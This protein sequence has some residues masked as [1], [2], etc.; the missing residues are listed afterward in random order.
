MFDEA[1]AAH[2]RID[3]VVSTDG[4]SDRPLILGVDADGTRLRFFGGD[5]VGMVTAE[6]LGADAAVV[7]ISCNDAIDRGA[8]A[9]D[10]RG[11]DAHRLAVR[12]RRH[13]GRAREGQANRV[14]LGSQW[15]LPDRLRDHS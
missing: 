3:A 10:H 13:G 14:R 1:R 5:L 6:F 7:P 11:E 2:G 15:R 8:V 12:H 4:D 9:G